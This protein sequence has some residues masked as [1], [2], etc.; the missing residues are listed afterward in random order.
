MESNYFDYVK[1]A[2]CDKK[3]GNEIH[4]IAD[5]PGPRYHSECVKKSTSVKRKKILCYT[6]FCIG[7]MAVCIILLLNSFYEF[8]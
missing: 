5:F 6:F 2:M 4:L 7:L 3:I 1:C 8:F